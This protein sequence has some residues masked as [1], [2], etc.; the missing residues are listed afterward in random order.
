MKHKK[1]I[2]AKRL[3]GGAMLA[4]FMFSS[5]LLAAAERAGVVVRVVANAFQKQL[6]IDTT[7]NYIEDSVLTFGQPM[8]TENALIDR[9]LTRPEDRRLPRENNSI[10]FEDTETSRNGV[11][12]EIDRRGLIS[13]NGINMVDIFPNASE[14]W[15]R[16][17]FPH[18]W[19]AK[20]R[21]LAAAAA[22]QSQGR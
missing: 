18:A 17:N 4:V 22:Q 19:E 1:T 13:I 8:L 12:N 20:Q 10:I 15:L 3:F 9:L 16:Q 2:N 14:Q 21:E 7:G 5:S 6:F 11:L